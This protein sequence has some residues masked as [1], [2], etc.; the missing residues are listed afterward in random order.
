MKKKIRIFSCFALIA[1]LILSMAACS[2]LQPEKSE[3]KPTT[4]KP[5]TSAKPKPTPEPPDVQKIIETGIS[6]LESGKINK[7]IASFEQALEADPNNTQAAGYLK[8]AQ[9]EKQRLIQEH[10]NK[11]IKYFT[12][13]LLK[14]AMVEWNKVLE[15]DPSHKKALEYKERTQEQ[16]DALK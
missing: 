14:E 15:L 9:K 1:I 13:D 7:A 6:Q 16:L 5:K 8:K 4:T 11:G 12:E 3:P 2:I 10:L